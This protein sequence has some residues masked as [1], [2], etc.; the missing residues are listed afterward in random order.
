VRV[1]ADEG[2]AR[3]AQGIGAEAFTAGRHIVFDQGRY[4][5]GTRSG[6][7][8]L[9]HELTHVAQESQVGYQAKP[10]IWRKIKVRGPNE[11]LVIKTWH[12]L[13]R[14]ERISFVT[15][16]FPGDALARA[17]VEDMADAGDDFNFENAE[18][19]RIE[20]FKRADTSR[21]MRESQKDLGVHG[22]SFGYPS[23][24]GKGCGARVNKAA[25]KY[26]GPV[27]FDSEK[28]YYFELTE[29]GKKDAYRAITSLFTPQANKCDRTLIHCDYLASVLHYRVFAE[30]IGVKVFN[31]RVLYGKIPLTLKWNGF[32]DIESGAF[33]SSNR[34]S[35]QEV[36]PSSERDLV[37]GDH[38]IF[39]N[40]RAYDLV[41]K[42]IREA[43]RLENA[44]LVD[45]KGRDDI[46]LG[47][48]SGENTNAQMRGKLAQ[49]YNDV[50]LKAQAIVDKVKKPK[51]H[52]SAVKQLEI[53]FP[54]VTKEGAE[55]H[56]NGWFRWH[57][58]NVK[59]VPIK[60][61]DP[62]LLGLR[63]PGDPTRMNTVIRPVES[64]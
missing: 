28:S 59:L 15:K 31:D 41:N 44:V 46:F 49:R 9:A 6:R 54:N 22:K 40:H 30:T 16:L 61:T 1:H 7:R 56:I 42:K 45:K 64:A 27:Q 4:Q 11:W 55:W 57:R 50:V 52:A 8:L 20:V 60:A 34:I 14:A 18:E 26:W 17:I 32:E 21:R 62:E 47:H 35:L 13:N 10:T 3:L 38:V 39:W 29:D 5:P 58:I 33:R 48:G 19:L 25:R 63:D 2:A 23:H 51:E 37:I 36:R 24:T 12:E 53:D 43:W